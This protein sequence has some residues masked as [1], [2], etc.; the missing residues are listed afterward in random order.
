VAALSA[1]SVT[2]TSGS[3]VVVCA[4]A[5]W[6][7][8]IVVSSE[9]AKASGCMRMVFLLLGVWLFAIKYEAARAYG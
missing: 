2:F 9:I 3:A 7:V 6:A 5:W 4:W 8:A 1:P